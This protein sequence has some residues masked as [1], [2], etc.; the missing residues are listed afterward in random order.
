[1]QTISERHFV[2]LLATLKARF[3]KNLIRH[4][5]LEWAKVEARH[6][7]LDTN[8]GKLRSLYEMERT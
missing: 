5:E 6:V 1:M 8:L 2:D 7:S 4:F 3:E